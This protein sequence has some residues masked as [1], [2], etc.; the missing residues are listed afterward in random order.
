MLCAL[1][2]SVTGSALCFGCLTFSFYHCSFSSLLF[3]AKLMLHI[4]S[5]GGGGIFYFSLVVGGGRLVGWWWGV[6]VCM[7]MCVC[8]WGGG[9]SK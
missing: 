1:S 2:V 7:C 9:G 3:V 5:W 8:V 4:C 6:V